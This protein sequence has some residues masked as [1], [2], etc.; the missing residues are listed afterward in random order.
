MSGLFSLIEFQFSCT[1]F[2][3][4]RIKV[5]NSG[6]KSCTNLAITVLIFCTE[7]QSVLV[8]AVQTVGGWG[9]VR[10]QTS[11]DGKINANKHPLPI[12]CTTR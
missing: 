12:I 7:I 9:R 6:C 4:Q 1:T 11:F 10:Q 3:F 8:W 2:Q 5:Q